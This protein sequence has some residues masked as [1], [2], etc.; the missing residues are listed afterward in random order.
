MLF[1]F[2]AGLTR[3]VRSV[4]IRTN[5]LSFFCTP[6]G[7]FTLLAGTLALYKRQAPVR[8]YGNACRL[9]LCL[10]FSAQDSIVLQACVRIIA[11]DLPMETPWVNSEHSQNIRELKN[12]Q[13]EA[14]GQKHWVIAPSDAKRSLLLP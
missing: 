4:G 8:R 7:Y 10:F 6:A 1:S 5:S 13:T 2:S 14:T 9:S 12:T 11:R 3:C